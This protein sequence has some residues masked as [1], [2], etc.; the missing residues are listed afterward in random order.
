MGDCI[1]TCIALHAMQVLHA[2]PIIRQCSLQE[3]AR[4][5]VEEQTPKRLYQVRGKFYELLVNCLPAELIL[6]RLALELTSKLDDE[7]KHKVIELAAF[8]EH[9]L[10]VYCLCSSSCNMPVIAPQHLRIGI[11]GC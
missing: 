10:Q 3:I 6:R 7:L 2:M 11:G 5:I 8:Y 9:R 1:F 4:D